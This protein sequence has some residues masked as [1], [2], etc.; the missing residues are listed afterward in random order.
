METTNVSSLRKIQI[1]MISR[2]MELKELTVISGN[3]SKNQ[4]HND[5]LSKQKVSVWFQGTQIL[6]QVKIT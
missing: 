5:S 6:N 2:E 1:T 3:N 4:T